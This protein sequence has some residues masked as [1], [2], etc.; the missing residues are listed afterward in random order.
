VCFDI[1]CE[2]YNISIL[3]RSYAPDAA[4]IAA[5]QQMQFGRVLFGWKHNEAYQC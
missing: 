2:L 5:L 4:V 3:Y 1:H